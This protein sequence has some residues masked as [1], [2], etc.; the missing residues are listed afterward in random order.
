MRFLFT[1]FSDSGH[2]NPMIAVAQYLENDGH[3]V[4][5]YS[6]QDDIAPRCMAA[7]LRAHCLRV[8]STPRVDAAQ[9]SLELSKRMSN[10]A[11]LKR[12][13]GAVLIDKVAIQTGQIRT[14]ARET[15]P[16]VIVAD[17]MSYAGAVA[18]DLEK[19]PWASVATGLQSRPLPGLNFPNEGARFPIV[20]F[21]RPGIRGSAVPID[22]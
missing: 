6:G 10:P 2:L 4:F 18:G 8:V 12:W 3:E 21:R 20:G 5:F 9:T 7:G 11:W 22:H 15:S 1:V 19:I 13:L 14:I 16:A 17:A